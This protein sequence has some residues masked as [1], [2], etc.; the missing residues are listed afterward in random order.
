MKED[1]PISFRVSFIFNDMK[2]ATKVSNL[3]KKYKFKVSALVNNNEVTF[4]HREKRL[5]KILNYLESKTGLISM[6]TLYMYF[7]R[8]SSISYKT[9]QRDIAILI[10]Q[11][12]I[13]VKYVN[14]KVSKGRATLI[15]IK[16]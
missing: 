10:L 16:K 11:N 9:I 6:T 7:S 5:K 3:L 15:E 8:H 1:K 14:D 12:K 13:N 4:M 2:Q